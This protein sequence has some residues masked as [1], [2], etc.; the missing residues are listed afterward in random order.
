MKSKSF[1]ILPSFLLL[2]GLVSGVVLMSLSKSKEQTVRKVPDFS[3]DRTIAKNET[4]QQ[5][6]K[7]ELSPQKNGEFLSG[8]KSISENLKTVRALD[9]KLS[10]ED[11][12]ELYTY[13]VTGPKGFEY[14]E[15]KNEILNKLRTQ[16]KP[17]PAF[18]EK[19]SSIIKNEELDMTLR[20]YSIQHLG[21]LKTED[22]QVAD[23]FQWMLSQG[24]P[25]IA[26]SG[27]IALDQSKVRH[28]GITEE[29]IAAKGLELLK[30]E[31][32]NDKLKASLLQICIEHNV[33]ETLGLAKNILSRKSCGA[34]ARVSAISVIGKQGDLADL[35]ILEQIA[36][37]ENMKYCRV[38]ANTAIDNIKKRY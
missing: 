12:E 19:L 32:I 25:D 10:D 1:Y 20:L 35:E 38:A 6:R 34:S 8:S 17:V 30:R 33:P 4:I 16:K 22:R 15:L 37:D 31:D 13:L 11:C 3:R 18:V 21:L 26:V 36:S 27:L 29:V 28:E 5:V 14:S 23:C 2:T 24:Q 9:D 7:T